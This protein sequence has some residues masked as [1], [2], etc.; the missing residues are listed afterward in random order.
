MAASEYCTEADLYDY[1]LPR[2]SLPNPGRLVGAVTVATDIVT[3]NGHGFRDDAQ[4]LFR[5]EGGGTL[6]AELV[7]GTTYYAI[8]ATS[9][10]FQVAAA[11]GG[12]AINLTTA[13]SNVVVGTPLPFATAI[14][15]ASGMVDDFLVGHT[16]PLTEPYPETV[17][18][19]TADLA[20]TR[21]TAQTEGLDK[22]AVLFKL[23][24]A[25]KMLARWQKGITVRGAVVP[26][27]NN[28]AITSAAT[29]V[30]PRGWVPT[31]GTLP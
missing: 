13:G 16:V 5:A 3:L 4:L 15:W 21:L 28:L 2:G 22:D 27:S 12:A 24:E 18:A 11:A 8:V 9:S 6:P 7:E 26:A 31:G 30:D 17:I 14:Q 20:I 25:Q 1:G 29:S 19:V 23:T 10:T